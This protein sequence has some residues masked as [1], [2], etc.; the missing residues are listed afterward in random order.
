MTKAELINDIAIATGYDKASVSVIVEAFM[1]NVKKNVCKGEN[2]YLRTFGSFITKTRK[3]KVA[4]NI[5]KETS[6]AV[7]A[8]TIAAFKPAAEFADEA[9]KLAPAK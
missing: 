5:S 9:R 8:H 4:R 1:E 7:P 3:A 2:V 6:V